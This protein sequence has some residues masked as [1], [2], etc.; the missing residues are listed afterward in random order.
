MPAWAVKNAWTSS[1]IQSY[2]NYVKTNGPSRSGV[3]RS[4]CEDLSIRMVV[5]FAEKHKLPVFFCNGANPRGLD[6][7][8]FSSKAQYLNA[9][10]PST[11]ASDL[12]DY[13]TVTMVSGARKGNAAKSLPLAKSGD[14]IILYRGG[15]HVQVVTATGPGKVEIVQGNFRPKS[16][17]CGRIRRVLSGADQNDPRSACYIGAIVKKQAYVRSGTPAQWTYAGAGDEFAQEGRL[18]IWDFESWNEFVPNY[19]PARAVA[20]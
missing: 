16:E 12:L 17:R 10:L 4:T 9:V 2:R 15:G 1:M 5:D 14:L 18:C 7:A 6:P 8:R 20:R 3:S 13:D 11:G 19:R